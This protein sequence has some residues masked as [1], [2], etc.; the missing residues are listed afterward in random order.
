MQIVEWLKSIGSVEKMRAAAKTV[1]A[2]P[3]KV[4]SHV[5]LPPNFSAFTTVEQVLDLAVAQDVRVIGVTNYYDYQVYVKFSELAK[6]ARVF[7]IFGL[8]IISLIDRLVKDKVKINDPG[9]PGRMYICGKGV[10]RFLP[11]P[12]GPAS[13]LETI[14]ANDTQRMREMVDKVAALF[15]AAGC[16]L[17]VTEPG[18]KKMISNR[19]KC[20]EDIVYLQ[21]RHIAQA[22][23]E[24]LFAKVSSEKRAQILTQV[25]GT[26]PKAGADDAVQFQNEFRS[27][28]LK[29]GKPAFV[30]ETFVNEIEAKK[31]ILGMG[32]IPCYPT[33]ADGASPLC[34]YEATPEIL[35]E[36]ILGMGIYMA[37][38]IPIRNSPEV[39]QTYVKAMRAA[40][41]VVVGGTEHNTLELIPLEPTCLKSAPV[42]EDIKAIFWEGA[43]VIA[44]HQFLLAQGQAGFVD[45]DGALCTGYASADARIKAFAALGAAVI[46]TDLGV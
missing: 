24:S 35:I 2:I 5:H 32:G 11:V 16:D 23:Q 42:P 28:L 14:R 46:Q 21:E 41:L 29:A 34:P 31:M 6:K 19:H 44:A 39:L 12:A 1:S 26:A 30:V 15:I 25:Y 7:P 22:F 36:N 17:S 8:E 3:L 40:G 10:T 20:P 13:I 9:N 4:N 45:A 37:E 18:V 38:F 27:H 43:C 33:L